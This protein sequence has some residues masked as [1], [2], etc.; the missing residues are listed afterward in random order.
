MRTIFLAV[1][2]VAAT[3][4]FAQSYDVKWGEF[5]RIHGKLVYLLPN[6]EVPNEFYALRWSGGT[7]LGRYM[8]SRHVD[9]NEAATGRLSTKVPGGI[10]TFEGARVVGGTLLTFLSDRRG[11]ERVLYMQKYSKEL[12]PVDESVHLAT[13]E[14]EKLVD[15]GWFDVIK[16]KNEKY[17]AVVWEIPAKKGERDRYGFKIFDTELNVI[18]EGD[19]RL[20]FDAEYSSIHN[21]Q[22]SNNGEYFISITEYK[23]GE[24]R[25]VF[26]NDLEFKA[27]HIF[28]IA[29]DGLQDFTLDV[30][31]KRI[32]AL[33]ISAE[34]DSVLTITG[35][36]GP[37]DAAGVEGV[38]FQRVNLFSREVLSEGFKEFDKDFITQDWSD[39]D[40]QRAERREMRGKGEPQLY[41]YIMR[42]AV[43]MDD[44]SIVGTMEQYYVQIRATPTSQTGD[45]SNTYQYY[46]NDIITYKINPDGEFEWVDKI[47]KYQVSTN[48]GGPY[49]SFESFVD[50]GMLYFIFNDNIENYK[51]NGAFADPESIY[52]ATYSRKR[53]TVALVRVDLTTGEQERKTFFDRSEIGALVVPKMFDVNYNTG[54]VL[55][56]AIWGRKEKFGVINLED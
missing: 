32:H 34:K 27:V 5:E 49:S 37:Q 6:S 3:T 13:Y 35:I 16:S 26:R 25:G 10:G 36:Y 53:N 51:E 4:A 12:E 22:L 14:V 28:H 33:A 8:V 43:I 23:V 40:L 29:E 24:R 19:Y 11:D 48:D 47:D 17:F 52:A 20:P 38:F 21:H 46:Y 7:V 41:N 2:M 9:M 39:R 55:I 42:E 50:D 15:R 18:N 1:F 56:Y 30:D 54:E 45:Y 31:E 44:G